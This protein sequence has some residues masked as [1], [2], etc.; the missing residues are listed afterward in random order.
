MFSARK[1]RG[2]VVRPLIQAHSFEQFV[3][4]VAATAPGLCRQRQML[5]GR[6]V[7]E[8]VVAGLLEHDREIVALEPSEPPLGDGVEQRVAQGDDPAVRLLHAGQDAQQRA[9]AGSRRTEQCGDRTR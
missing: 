6:E 4:L 3:D 5:A 9:L 8:Q 2:R 1:L 7:L